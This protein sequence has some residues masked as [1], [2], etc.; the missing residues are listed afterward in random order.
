MSKNKGNIGSS[1]SGWGITMAT[2]KSTRDHPDRE[3]SFD[4]IGYVKDAYGCRGYCPMKKSG[5]CIHNGHHS[6]HM[7]ILRMNQVLDSHD[8]VRTRNGRMHLMNEQVLHSM[9]IMRELD[10]HREKLRECNGEVGSKKW[11]DM[12]D[13]YSRTHELLFGKLAVIE[14]LELKREGLK[15]EHGKL[16]ASDI[17]ALMRGDIKDAEV[18]EEVEVKDEGLKD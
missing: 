15:I 14:Q 1:P 8:R 17:Q 13:R 10:G 9:D 3:Y 18:V 16:K 4:N 6:N 5:S 7:C 12:Y 11:L 2:L